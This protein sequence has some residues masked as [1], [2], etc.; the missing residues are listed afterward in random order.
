VQYINKYKH[1]ELTHIN[2]VILYI[3]TVASNDVYRQVTKVN[4]YLHLL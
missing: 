4:P 3:K 1:L 2:P